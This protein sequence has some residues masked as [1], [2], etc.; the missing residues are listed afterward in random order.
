MTRVK[1]CGVTEVEDARDAALLGADAIGLN[2]SADSPRR[3][4]PERAMR[5]IESLPPFVSAVGVFV[6]Y[7]DP[8]ALE[9]F[10]VSIRLDAVQLHGT[11][12]PDYCSMIGRVKV[13]KAF[14]VNDDFKIESLGKYPVSGLLL[15]TY[16]KSSRGGT[17]RTFQWVP[18][19]GCQR[20]WSHRSCWWSG[21][22]KRGA[23]DRRVASF[24]CRR[25]QRCR[26]HRGTKRL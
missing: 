18:S 8:Q 25:R 21:T 2:F 17:G 10:A 24:C 11:E 20:V 26:A 12:S 19:G 13:I 23:G 16:S 3:V 6:N 7:E 1:I 5:I 14:S 4:M 15:D 9:D 22:G